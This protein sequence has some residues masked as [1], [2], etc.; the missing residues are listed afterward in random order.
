[1]RIQI[2]LLSLSINFITKGQFDS[3]GVNTF[4]FITPRSYAFTNTR[5]LDQNPFHFNESY[6]WN[7]NSTPLNGRV[8]RIDFDD[9]FES[10]LC[11]DSI[12]RITEY[13]RGELIDSTNSF[14][15]VYEYDSL[16]RLKTVTQKSIYWGNY[17]DQYLYNEDSTGIKKRIRKDKRTIN[18][19]FILQ[20]GGYLCFS[21]HHRLKLD[22]LNRIIE[23]PDRMG[24]TPK[25]FIYDTI[26][27]D[28]IK[29]ERVK[30]STREFIYDDQGRLF[31]IESKFE[32]QNAESLE[33][34]YDPEGYWVDTKYVSFKDGE[35]RYTQ[36]CIMISPLTEMETG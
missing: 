26:Q 3:S 15:K 8:K 6:S 30:N 28:R 34:T 35:V 32:D 16:G 20:A 7:L 19:N 33:F 21:Y 1:M 17:I 24:F 36:K 14:L 9:G 13:Q 29:F 4:E 27:T 10:H 12:G 5:H 2:L 23:I 25:F 11:F 18:E 22:S 31:K